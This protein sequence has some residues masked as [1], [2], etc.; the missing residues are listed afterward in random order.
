[1]DHV[2]GR[3]A[4]TNE[5]ADLMVCMIAGEEAGISALDEWG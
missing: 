1:V 4:M 2:G 3:R 5:D